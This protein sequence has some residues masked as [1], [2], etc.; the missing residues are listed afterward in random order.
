M[1]GVVRYYYEQL[2]NFKSDEALANI[3]QMSS[4]DIVYGGYRPCERSQYTSA[5]IQKVTSPCT[6]ALPRGFPKNNIFGSKQ[7]PTMVLR[8]Q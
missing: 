8:A 4:D 1:T 6:Q 2:H 3:L 5:M 7:L